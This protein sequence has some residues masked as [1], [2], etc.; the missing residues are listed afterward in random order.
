MV[1]LETYI[2]FE[3]PAPEQKR[4]LTNTK[5]QYFSYF[6]WDIIKMFALYAL[7][8]DGNNIKPSN[9]KSYIF[10]FSSRRKRKTGT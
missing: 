3:Q 10:I 8:L 6:S 9:Y 4:V 5:R 1:R 7:Y 2:P